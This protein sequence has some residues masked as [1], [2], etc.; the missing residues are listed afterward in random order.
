MQVPYKG[1]M[2]LLRDIWDKFSKILSVQDHDLIMFP[3]Q[4]TPPTKLVN[5][6]NQKPKKEK[7]KTTNQAKK[8]SSHGKNS[9]NKE[10]LS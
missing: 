9:I 7:I 10:K 6:L 8:I 5:D 2:M 3:A 1:K 4:V